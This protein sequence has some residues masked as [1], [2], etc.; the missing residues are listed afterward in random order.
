MLPTFRFM[1]Q[2]M[3]L[4]ALFSSASPISKFPFNGS[5]TR[6][7]SRNPTDDGYEKQLTKYY[8]KRFHEIVDLAQGVLTKIR[9][10]EGSLKSTTYSLVGYYGFTIEAGRQSP[11]FG[12]FKVSLQKI[13]QSS[14]E[15]TPVQLFELS[16]MA[17]NR[18]IRQHTTIEEASKTMTSLEFL[19]II[20]DTRDFMEIANGLAADGSQQSRN[21]AF[22]W[23]LQ[24]LRDEGPDYMM[25]LT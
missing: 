3:G 10:K 9:A 4:L 18:D 19:G 24:K 1:V 13:Y 16:Q 23:F 15:K 22:A 25:S 12:F 8:F 14:F 11:N 5:P 20:S 7:Q 21:E 6:I 17:S 2:V